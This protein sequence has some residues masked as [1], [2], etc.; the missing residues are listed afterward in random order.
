MYPYKNIVLP[1]YRA[2]DHRGN[3]FKAHLH[4]KKKQLKKNT[5]KTIVIIIKKGNVTN[6]MK[7]KIRKCH[8]VL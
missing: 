5:L 6:E 1:V 3:N 8:L 2:F 4:T 7:K